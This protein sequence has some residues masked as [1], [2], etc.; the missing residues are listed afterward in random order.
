MFKKFKKTQIT[1]NGIAISVTQKR[2]RSLRLRIS[3]PDAA[4]KVSAPLR[5]SL[6]QIESFIKAKIEWIKNHRQKILSKKTAAKKFI[7]GEAHEFLGEKYIL[8]ILSTKKKNQIQIRDNII[9]MQLKN[10]LN[11]EQKRKLMEE[12]WRLHLK[13][14]VPQYISELEKKMNVRVAEFGIKKMKTRWGT[15]NPKARR[16]WLNLELAKKPLK[17]LEYLIIH[18]MVHLLERKHSKKFYAYMDQFMP[19][20]HECKKQLSHLAID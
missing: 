17:C 15:C 4:I 8:K 12:F 3:H 10:Y 11:L 6:K 19:N 1:I 5:L 9:E 14:I 16:I 13:K 18:E 20:W 2:M 7:D